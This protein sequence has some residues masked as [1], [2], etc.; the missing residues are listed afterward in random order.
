VLTILFENEHFILV[1]KPGG[2]LSV[3]SQWGEEDPRP[4]LNIELSKQFGQQIWPVHRLDLDV[5]GVV[6]FAKN[7]RAHQI[8]NTWFEKRSIDKTYE[9]WTEGSPPKTNFFEWNSML[10]RGKKRSFVSP[11]GKLAV[12]RALWKKTIELPTGTV[13]DW[14]L[15]PITG[16]PHQLRV[17]LSSNGYP[18]VGDKLYGATR[19]FLPNTLALRAVKLNFSGC[20]EAE[21]LGLPKELLAPSLEDIFKQSAMQLQK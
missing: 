21:S 20:D 4:V 11:K 17:H 12:T 9:A 19:E 5:T 6:L 3:P 16:R 10:Q 8:A 1:D 13:Q 15:D 2:W 18:I 14:V 7:A